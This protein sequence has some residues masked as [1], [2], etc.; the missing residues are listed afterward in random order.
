MECIIWTVLISTSLLFLSLKLFGFYEDAFCFVAFFLLEMCILCLFLSFSFCIVGENFF[1]QLVKEI[2]VV[3]CLKVFDN[4]RKNVVFVRFG[5]ML[6]FSTW[7]F[8]FLEPFTFQERKKERK[9]R[10]EQ[11]KKKKRRKERNYE[12]KKLNCKNVRVSKN[13]WN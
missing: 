8:Q 3:F 4:A 7:H 12:G 5:L 2:V 10:N 1:C 6:S 13:I 9:K 11:R